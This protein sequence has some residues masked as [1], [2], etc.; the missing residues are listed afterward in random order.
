MESSFYGIGMTEPTAPVEARRQLDQADR[1][2]AKVAAQ[3]R[4]LPVY[5]TAFGLGAG[6]ETFILGIVEQRAARLAAF[7]VT[8]VALVVTMALWSRSHRATVRGAQSRIRPWWIATFTLYAVAAFLWPAVA[9]HAAVRW[10]P[11]GVVVAAPLLIGAWRERK[12]ELQ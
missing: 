7:T 2:A 11:A 12:R 9:G 5:M 3:G 1:A 8:W 6:A 10:L 4:W